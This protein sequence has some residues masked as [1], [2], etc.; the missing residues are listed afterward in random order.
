MNI[1][2]NKEFTQRVSPSEIH[3]SFPYK[4]YLEVYGTN[5]FG[6]YIV[7]ASDEEIDIEGNGEI[8]LRFTDTDD[9]VVKDCDFLARKVDYLT[10]KREDTKIW[11]YMKDIS[12]TK[13][14]KTEKKTDSGEGM[15]QKWK[16]MLARKK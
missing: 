9:K 16:M 3:G 11:V 8:R 12:L 7:I 13:K 1:M 5:L 14:A 6:K 10:V 4:L 2:R 15:I